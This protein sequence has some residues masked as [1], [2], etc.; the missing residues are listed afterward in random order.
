[1]IVIWSNDSLEDVEGIRDFIAR[2]SEYYA[3]VFTEKIIS[4][5]EKLIDFP[6][7]G[8][9]VPEYNTANIR[10]IIYRNYR[11]IYEV[12]DKRVVILSVLHGS[13]QV[14]SDDEDL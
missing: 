14:K 9:I 5:A 7:M 1:M 6:L 2:D 12:E 3:N 10:E 4:V 13:Q 11:V 8:R